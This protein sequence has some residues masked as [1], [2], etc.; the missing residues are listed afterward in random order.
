MRLPAR[1]MVHCGLV[2]G[3]ESMFIYIITDVT[4]NSILFVQYCVIRVTYVKLHA[5]IFLLQSRF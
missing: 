2:T 1:S 3:Y 5:S 4:Q